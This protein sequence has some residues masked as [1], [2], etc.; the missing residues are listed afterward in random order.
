[1]TQTKAD[2]RFGIASGTSTREFRRWPISSI[3]SGC[4]G[5]EF[6]GERT[7]DFAVY[8]QA[9]D[10]DSPNNYAEDALNIRVLEPNKIKL[11]N[12]KLTMNKNLADG[13]AVFTGTHEFQVLH[14][15]TVVGRCAVGTAY[16]KLWW[17][18]STP[19]VELLSPRPKTEEEANWVNGPEYFYFQRLTGKIIDIRHYPIP[20][21][22]YVDGFNDGQIIYQKRQRVKI[23][24]TKCN[25][26]EGEF[27]SKTYL[28]TLKKIDDDT[29]SLNAEEEQ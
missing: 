21:A 23:T 27:L 17:P 29:L 26:D 1:M 5:L 6:K 18:F 14:G 19:M 11:L 28:L 24:F 9:V 4:H 12:P 7:G 16:E 3:F 15:D 22:T 8:S 13:I 2:S 20:N 25:G 10:T